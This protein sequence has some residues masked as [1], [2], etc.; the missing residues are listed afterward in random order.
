MEE[1]SIKRLDIMIMKFKDATKFKSQGKCD[2]LRKQLCAEQSCSTTNK[3][4][5]R[6]YMNEIFAGLMWLG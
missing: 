1:C 2:L 3:V 5:Y 4:D 6:D